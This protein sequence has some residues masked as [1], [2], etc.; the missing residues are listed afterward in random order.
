MGNMNK[1]NRK[2]ELPDVEQLENELKRERYRR[3][4]RKTFRGTIYSLIVVA[5]IAVLVAAVSYT[6]LTLPT[7]AVV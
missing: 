3:E 5:S 6:H 4:Y 2:I 7:M 1:D